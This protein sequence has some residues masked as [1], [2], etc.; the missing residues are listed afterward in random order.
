MVVAVDDV[1][2]LHEI[3]IGKMLLMNGKPEKEFWIQKNPKTNVE[4]EKHGKSIHS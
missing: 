2:A 1:L 3:W 4:N